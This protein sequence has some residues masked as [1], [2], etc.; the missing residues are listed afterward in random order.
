MAKCVTCGAELHPERA[1]KY[2]YCTRPECRA[3]NARP[4][5]IASIG[6]NKASDQFVV[7]DDRTT[8]EMAGGRYRDAGRTSTGRLGHRRSGT[9]PSPRR[10]GP[11]PGDR[12]APAETWSK[13]EQNLA[14][15][16]EVTGRLPIEEIAIRLG[17]DR[18]T[19]AKMLV[20]AKA[21]WNARKGA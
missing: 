8:A 13:D 5:T 1:E 10:R 20:A 6:V 14:L 19:V 3:R 2:R 18:A 11:T 16:Y 15:A 21:G 9:D 17:R 12:A 7:L 4:R